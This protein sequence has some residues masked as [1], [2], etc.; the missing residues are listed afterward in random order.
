MI[1]RRLSNPERIAENFDVFDFG[2][3]RWMS[4]S[5]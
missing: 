2:A 3:V 1:P 4:N 5:P